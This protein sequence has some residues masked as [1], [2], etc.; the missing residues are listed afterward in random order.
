MFGAIAEGLV[1]VLT[2]VLQQSVCPLPQSFDV[3]MSYC[4]NE[5]RAPSQGEHHAVCLGLCQSSGATPIHASAVQPQAVCS[6]ELLKRKGLSSE[7]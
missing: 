1:S 4:D 6:W 5:P 2:V 3:T 7:P